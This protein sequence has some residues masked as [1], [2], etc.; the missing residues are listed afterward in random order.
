MK[1]FVIYPTYRVLN[2][3]AQVM[4]FGR[5]ENGESFV[6]INDF[7]PYFWIKRTDKDT[8]KKVLEDMKTENITIKDEPYKNFDDEKMTK[9][10]LTI[11]KEVRELKKIFQ[12]KNITCYEADLRFSYRFMF[13]N[14]IR[15]SMKIIGKARKPKEDE[16]LFVDNVFEN[17]E[18]EPLEYWP[19]LDV[20][21]FDIETTLKGDKIFAI[22]LYSKKIKKVLLLKEEGEYKNAEIFKTEKE[23]LE[24]FKRFVLQ[25]DPDVLTGWNVI[26]FDLKILKD[27]FRK[28]NIPFI[29]GRTDRECTLRLTD[30]FFTDSSANFQG[31]AVI[32]GIHLMKVSF[33]RLDD[34]KLNTAAKTILGEEKLLTSDNRGEEI[35]ELY[36]KD[37]QKLVDYNLKDSELVYNILEKS[38]TL[39]LS[40]KRSLLTGM[41]LDRVNASIA[42]LDSLYLREL[43]ERKLVAPSAFANESSERIKGGF[44]MSSKPGI[45]K[46]IIVLDFKSLYPSIIRTFNIDPYSFVPIEQYEKLTEKEKEGLIEA[47]NGAHFKNQDGILPMI[48]TKL[49]AQRDIAKKEKDKLTN[50]AIKILMNSFFGVLANPTCRFYSLE[51]ANGITH[52]GQ[53]LN[54]LTAEK[55][56]EKGYEV[57]YGDSVSKD[58]KVIIKVPNGKIKSVH[59][60]DLFK[61]TDKKT[62]EGKQY[63]F[64]ENLKVLTLDKFGKSTFQKIEYVMRHKV[65][66]KIFRIYFTNKW[67]IDVTEDHSLIGY[68]N[69]QKNNRLKDLER[70]IEVKPNEIGSK[71]RSIITIK[72]IPRTKIQNRGYPKELYEFAGFFLGDGSF[73]RHNKKNYYLH[74]SGGKDS[75]E[76]IDK[77]IVPLKKQEFIKNYWNKKK[78]DICINGMKLIN[79]FNDECRYDNKKIIP[80]FI[81]EESEENICSFIR[82]AFSADGTVS[83]RNNKP[84]IRFTNTN[85]KFIEG[86]G[87]LL[88]YV[89]I[90]NSIFSETK[91]NSYMGKVSGSISKHIYIKDQN[92]FT[93]KIGFLFKRKEKRLNLVS[94]DSTHKRTIKNYDFDL[95]KTTKIEEIKYNDYVYDLEVKDTHRFFANNILVHNTDSIFVNTGKE[96]IK[97]AEKIGKEL[98]I[99]IN[100]FYN[101]YVVDYKRESFLELEFEKAFKKFL[102]PKVRGSEKGAKKRYAGLIEKD[103]K[104][105]ITITGL[106]FVRRDWTDV[107]KKFQM[108]LLEHIFHDQPID[109]YIKEFVDDLKNGKMDSLLVYKKAIRKMVSEYTKTTPPHIKAARK[110]GREKPGLIEYVMT[111]NGPEIIEENPSKLDYDH[112]IE[113][114]I[115]PIA[116]SILSF[117]DK[118]FDDLIAKHKQTDLS[119]WG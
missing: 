48:L 79:L 30:S 60:S 94:V 15:A 93:K 82:G 83:I 47:P 104:E 41:Q 27:Q 76:L 54:K 87:N 115:K 29:L 102:M 71:V 97:E 85:N 63:N 9:V 65:R 100:E 21:S 91:N 84:L 112:Y 34:Y 81:F 49:W 77:L 16:A 86:I 36:E 32:D 22:S 11:P 51:M 2:N 46:G 106:E 1:A 5:L 31:R 80:K 78:G 14:R 53:F 114:Q 23:M 109:D 95:A 40:I 43:K 92:S 99:Y 64:K 38:N 67:F 17:P 98:E 10:I 66:K 90:S 59:I 57:I 18:F 50:Q 28:Y 12:D 24:S 26:D 8:A 20:L 19:E 108:D 44:V 101:N 56:R 75:K 117:Q 4:L 113:K 119:N 35:E 116:D 37:P 58:T 45:Y 13:D 69:K 62:K 72:K 110:V 42:S 74:V 6:T 96:D 89:G 88:L 73:D 25:L 52:F 55:I 105:E 107:S 111:V 103:G 7:Q 68:I 3:K 39:N 61:K 70:L 33:L 118:S